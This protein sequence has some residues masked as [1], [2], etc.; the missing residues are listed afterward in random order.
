[1]FGERYHLFLFLIAIVIA[2]GYGGYGPSLLALS[3]SWL[4][5]F[6]LVPGDDSFE[7]RSQVAFFAV[8]VAITVL[9][10]SLRAARE[11]TEHDNSKLQRELEEQQAEREWHQVSLA[12]IA[13]AVLTTDPKGSVIFLNPVASRL[14]RMDLE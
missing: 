11:R 8:G 3:L 9:G 13:D 12:S 6:F 2:T 7:F 4:S 5:V 1:M 14:H 10:G